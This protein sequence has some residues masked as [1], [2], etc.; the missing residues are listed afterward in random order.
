MAYE[1][2]IAGLRETWAQTASLVSSIEPRDLDRETPCPGWSV[3]DVV[4]HLIGFELMLAGAPMPEALSEQPPHV[5]ND[6][7]K[8]NEAFVAARRNHSQDEIVA[9]FRA[10]SDAS[11]QRLEAMSDEAWE[12]PSW[13]PEGEVPYHRFMETRILD[14]W[15]HLQDLRDALAQPQD[16]HG[17]GEE[18]V[19]NRF[20]SYLPYVVGKR[21][22]APEG[23]RVRLNLIGRLGRNIDVEVV[24]GRARAATE[25]G[26]PAVE[27]TTPV[28]LFWR[29]AAGRISAEAFLRA[30]ETD[31]RGDSALA[32]RIAEGLATMI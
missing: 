4:S 2:L 20:E 1:W 10:V 29:R 30:A 21:A 11:L 7:G 14:S 28:A 16:D 23:T 18:I 31:V 13:S 3:R 22:Q 24:D 12:A 19:V 25:P 32:S 17:I 9:E 8:I 5:K 27:I 26:E 15:I 6:I